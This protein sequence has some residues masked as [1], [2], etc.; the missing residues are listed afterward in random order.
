MVGLQRLDSH[1]AWTT[2]Q[3]V[4]IKR[5]HLPDGSIGTGYVFHSPAYASD[6]RTHRRATARNAPGTSPVLH[7]HAGIG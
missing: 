3:R 2:V 5:Q 4:E 7:I 1:G 6:L